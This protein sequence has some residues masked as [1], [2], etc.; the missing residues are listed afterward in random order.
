[1]IFTLA[2]L[3]VTIKSDPIGIFND[4]VELGI[5]FF[6]QIIQVKWIIQC[7]SPFLEAAANGE[8]KH[9]SIRSFSII[10]KIK[11]FLFGPLTAF[12]AIPNER[13]P[14]VNWRK[15]RWGPYVERKSYSNSD[16]VQMSD[17]EDEN[18]DDYYSDDDDDDAND[19]RFYPYRRNPQD[20]P[21]P[22]YPPGYWNKYWNGFITRKP[23]TKPNNSPIPFV[24]IFDGFF[25]FVN[26]AFV[27]TI[28]KNSCCKY[29][30]KILWNFFGILFILK[31]EI[32]KKIK[33]IKAN[34]F[35]WGIHRKILVPW[36]MNTCSKLLSYHFDLSWL[37]EQKC[38]LLNS[39][40]EVRIILTNVAIVFVFVWRRGFG[41]IA[42]KNNKMQR[43]LISFSFLWCMNFQF[44]SYKTVYQ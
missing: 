18:Y 29:K 11:E 44:D 30:K 43:L 13:V 12:D 19:N 10:E 31:I 21:R 16:R 37:Q 8:V 34:N 3:F 26:Y 15:N 27:F 20:R 5:F 35:R 28:F 6:L 2:V 24:W 36:T 4:G 42:K 32:N 9:R 14:R 7:V 41:L 22:T 1:M 25:I 40:S 33:R 23:V 17:S 38:N 39:R